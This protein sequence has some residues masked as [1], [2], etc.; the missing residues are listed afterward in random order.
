MQAGDAA[1]RDCERDPDWNRVGLLLKNVASR[2][3]E[4][5]EVHAADKQRQTHFI[6][7]R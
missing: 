1:D 5:R 7:R 4:L 2:A 6:F 3:P